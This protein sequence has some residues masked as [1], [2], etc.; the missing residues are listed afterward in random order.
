MIEL[1][2]IPGA[3]KS[4]I[5]D[6]LNN[7]DLKKIT[8]TRKSNDWK[9][10]KRLFIFSNLIIIVI[11][12]FINPCRWKMKINSFKWLMKH[13]FKK[14]R[15]LIEDEGI[16]Q[17]ILGVLVPETGVLKK[18][19]KLLIAKLDLRTSRVN[20]VVYASVDIAYKRI[21]NRMPIMRFYGLSKVEIFNILNGFDL[22]LCELLK[23]PTFQYYLMDNSVDNLN[24]S[25]NLE[26]IMVSIND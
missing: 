10:E 17:R 14:D 6:Y 24:L 8:H 11:Y 9:K 15:D 4:Y 3:G 21:E 22:V 13:I 18:F 19:Q 20:I 23:N 1:V 26:N 2:G 12:I 16:I 25:E 5:C 7:T